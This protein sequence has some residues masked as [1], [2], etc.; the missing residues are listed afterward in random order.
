M[1]EKTAMNNEVGN[2]EIE[3]EEDGV[4]LLGGLTML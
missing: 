3:E 4:R 1:G 2:C